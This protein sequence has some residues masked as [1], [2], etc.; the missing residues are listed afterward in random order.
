MAEYSFNIPD[1]IMGAV[2]TTQRQKWV[3]PRYK[4]YKAYKILVRSLADQKGVPD[5]LDKDS[6]C[7]VD[8]TAHWI[9]KQ[10]CDGDN[11]IKGILDAIFKNDKRV[12]YINYR[13]IENTGKETANVKIHITQ[14]R[15]DRNIRHRG[16]KSKS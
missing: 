5:T 6:S 2:R 8:I 14:P 16:N 13:A 12:L 15:K 4:K 9:K 3:D 10:R 11:V 7:A 1:I